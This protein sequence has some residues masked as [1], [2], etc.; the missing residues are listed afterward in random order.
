MPLDPN[1][2]DPSMMRKKL[3]EKQRQQALGD[4]QAQGQDAQDALN[5]RFASIGGLASGA[6]I[7]QQQILQDKIGQQRERA[8]G[9]VAD[10]ESLAELEE[11]RDA[12]NKAFTSGE[13]EKQR[14]F[15]KGEAQVGRDFQGSEAAKVRALQSSQFDKTF[16]LNREQF[17]FEKP[18]K[19]RQLDMERERLDLEKDQA[20]YNKMLSELER[21]RA[22]RGLLGN[23]APGIFGEQF[24]NNFFTQSG[25]Q[26]APLLASTAGIGQIG[27]M[28]PGIGG[29]GGGGL[30]IIGGG[31]G[32]YFC[33]AIHENFK[34]TKAQRQVLKKLGAYTA[35]NFSYFWE[36]YQE[37]APRIIAILRKRGH[38]F[39][40]DRRW[41]LKAIKLF[42][43]DKMLGM[44]A[45]QHAWMNIYQE[46]KHGL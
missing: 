28:I 20:A 39:Y 24:G 29:G 36:F 17:E 6:S 46:V 12:A 2:Q 38:K 35:N 3:F 42:K 14:G 40:N 18:L 15:L 30:P 32:S 23:L 16:G 1:I 9:G 4:I 41:V 5:R 43:K 11:A 13:A 21:S 22:E 27:K 8:L 19:L 44:L 31:G 7:K 10:R 33:S 25:V 26:G 45:Y 34:W 37:Q